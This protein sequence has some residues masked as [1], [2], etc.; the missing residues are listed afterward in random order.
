[1]VECSGAR[2]R[3]VLDT[4]QGLETAYTGG[5]SAGMAGLQDKNGAVVGR[6]L[7]SDQWVT[8]RSPEGLAGAFWEFTNDISAIW[9]IQCCFRVIRHQRRLDGKGKARLSGPRM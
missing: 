5:E 2:T 1:M 6:F 3:L 9:A 8:A 7:F 4:T